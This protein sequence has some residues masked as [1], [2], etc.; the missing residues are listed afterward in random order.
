MSVSQ[1]TESFTS[2]N[3]ILGSLS[4]EALTRLL[5]HIEHVEL[6][7]GHILYDIDDEIQHNYFPNVGMIS[8]VNVEG[9]GSQIE[10]GV[11]GREGFSGIEGLLDGPGA[12]NRQMV[13]LPGDGYRLPTNLLRQE[14]YREGPFQRVALKLTRALLA[15][16]SQTALCNRLHKAEQR[17]AK[18]LL[19]CHDRNG[20]DTM[21]IT[22]EFAAIMLGANRTS[23]TIAAGHLQVM[24]FIRY[25]RGKISMT[26]RTGLEEFACECY[27]KITAEYARLAG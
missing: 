17:L 11:I 7:H 9:D 21:R 4:G 23:V 24:G 18:W 2:R 10:V 14:L 6:E 13:Q 15:Q 8:V 22:Q 3:I 27:G 16:I 5:P 1:L 19:M 26:D 12:I 25:T 20:S